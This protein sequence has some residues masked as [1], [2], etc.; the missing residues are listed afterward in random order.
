MKALVKSKPE[1]GLW[2]EDVPVP[3]FGPNDLFIKIVKT[4]ICGTDVHIHKWDEW[5]QKTIPVPMIVGHEFVGVVEDMGSEVVGFS[6]GDR[7]SGEGHITCG[8][9]RRCRG[10]G[11]HLC[12]NTK[13][14]GVNRTGAFAEYFVLPAGNAFLVP[15]D[16]ETDIACIFDPM[17]NAVHTTLSYDLVG[18]DVLVTGAGPIG[19]MSVAIAK[20]CGAR[21][22]VIT[23]VNDRRLELAKQMGATRIV[24]PTREK[25][26]DVMIEIG[27]DEGFDVGLEM[28]GNASA[29]QDMLANMINGGKIALLGIFPTAVSIDWDQVI[30]KGLFL[31]GIYGREMFD[32]WYKMKSMLQSGLDV[33]S[34][35]THRMPIDDFEQ[36]FELMKSGEA[37]KILLEW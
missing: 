32:T 22:V 16:I 20:H 11:Q 25:L 37:V 24:N 5:A 6:R 29:F 27:M 19:I 34:V 7:V 21:H 13:G 36:G 28:S 30:F 14:V 33:S 15:D 9:C 10:G 31:K 35:I 4:A 23:D 26:S 1:A 18:E 8:H 2:M 3:E 17:G 12:M